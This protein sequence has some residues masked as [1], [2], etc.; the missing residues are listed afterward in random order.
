[1]TIWTTPLLEREDTDV[2]DF[3]TDLS[4]RLGAE[5]AEAWTESPFEQTRRMGELSRAFGDT[6]HNL[7][8]MAGFVDQDIGGLLQP[9]ELPKTPMAEARGKVKEAGLEKALTLPPGDEIPTR[10]LDIMI[11]RA[12]ARQERAA[13]IARGPEGFIPG[14]LSLGTSFLVGAV[15]PINVASAFIP[16]VGEMR[17]A[18][19]LAEAGEGALA[20]AAAR[21]PIGIAS[22][23]VGMAAIEPINARSRLLEGQ[24]YTMAHALNNL[25][26]GAALGGILHTGGG[27]VADVVRTRRARPMFPFGEGEPYGTVPRYEDLTLPWRQG[28]AQEA[29]RAGEPQPVRGPLDAYPERFE[30]AAARLEGRPL[31]REASV[32]DDFSPNEVGDD[33]VPAAA[34]VPDDAPFTPIVDVIDDLP[35]RAREDAMRA[36]VAALIQGEPVQVGQMLEIAAQVDPRIAES[37]E[38]GRMSG[39][40]AAADLSPAGRVVFDDIRL[41]LSEAGMTMDEAAANAALVAA[42][43]E[44]RASRLQ[45]AGGTAED[46]YRAEGVLVRRND[47]LNDP[48]DGRTLDQRRRPPTRGLPGQMDLLGMGP[49]SDAELAQRRAN[50]PMRPGVAQRPMDEGLFGDTSAQTD[51]VDM[52]RQKGDRELF[53][54]GVRLPMDQESRYARA[55]EM[56]YDTSVIWYHGAR[57]SDRLTEK[58]KILAKRSTSGPMPYF[59]NDPELASSYS[60][61]KADTSLE[62]PGDYSGWFKFKVPG[63]R[64]TVDLDRAWWFLP[65]EDRQKAAEIAPRITFDEDGRQIVLG[66]PE[67]TNGIGSYDWEIKQARGNVLKALKES[68]LSSGALFDQEERFLDVLR[69]A[70]VRGIELD[71]PHAEASG[72]LPV[73][74]KIKNPLDTSNREL[75]ASLLPE[76]QAL[77][78]RSRRQPKEGADLWAKSATTPRVWLERFEADLRDGTTHA[79]TSIP[80]EVTRFLESKGFDAVL[81]K[82]NKMGLADKAVDVMIPFRPDQVRSIFAKFDPGSDGSDR[83]LAQRVEDEMRG[84]ITMSDNAAIIDLFSTADRSTFMHEMGH[85]WLDELARDAART[86]V[87]EGVKNDMDAVLR[88]LG[89]DRADAITTEQHEKWARAFEQYLQ[90]GKAPTEGLR[91]VFEQFKEWLTA[92]YRAVIGAQAPL[93]DE[94]RGVFDRLLTPEQKAEAT[95]G[96]AAQG[97]KR[98]RKPGRA[99]AD[100]DTFSI[101]EFMAARGGIRSDDPMAADVRAIFGGKNPFIPGFGALIRNPKELSTEAKI[102]GKTAPVGLDRLREGAA[103]A[104]Y[105]T[106]YG[107]DAMQTTT[108]S[109]LL[110]LMER[111]ARSEKV[112]REGYVETP[113]Q[114]KARL[115]AEEDQHRDFAEREIHYALKDAEI[116][117]A[118]VDPK[119]WDRTV[120]IMMKEG[121]DDPF[122]AYER[123]VMEETFNEQATHGADR[124]ADFIPGWDVADERQAAPQAGG[125]APGGGN[126]ARAGLGDAARQPRQDTGAPRGGVSGEPGA[127][128]TDAWNRL[129]N[130]T[131]DFDEPDV[132]ARSEAAEKVPDPSVIEADPKKALSAAQAAEMEAAAMFDNAAPYLPPDLVERVQR[133][134]AEVDAAV[135]DTDFVLKRGAACLASAVGVGAVI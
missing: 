49:I 2:K 51:L 96:V 43:Y 11:E 1:M 74:M 56:G 26:F 22:G 119:T 90:D 122:L 132:L 38:V 6:T 133:Q 89:A 83:L 59:T 45:G 85:L 54:R 34:M 44:A 67:T 76:L 88:W 5:A 78:S 13:T 62:A 91:A 84:R 60:T 29:A 114:E 17:Y 23:A 125:I 123:A 31:A 65:A 14:A 33:L 82:S 126:R 93:S 127:S 15:D 68:W 108:V 35:P 135:A 77:A 7:S 64:S 8:T 116:D 118:S 69:M 130:V 12:R 37:I 73:F 70:G 111:E 18:K 100:E 110:T 121:V 105:M 30:D 47:G 98:Q 66:G 117:P 32:L 42:R 24:D 129:A 113:A 99:G 72:V 58:H 86:R 124:I 3:K 48:L 61:K 27:A 57:R 21:A 36:S 94:I 104:G 120:Q 131:R 20:R 79:W 40:A 81:D 9:P 63:S 50:E 71:H 28:A 97:W 53:Q 102:G 10:A 109:D 87:P 16:V 134:L 103:E 115:A 41:Q 4:G 55:R 39:I 95:A 107:H 46:L 92:I 106:S 75:L 19:L 112:Y 25:I 80:D 52:A 101:L 128:P